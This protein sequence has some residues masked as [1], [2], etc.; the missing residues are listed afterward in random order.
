M[1]KG[2]WGGEQVGVNGELSLQKV[3]RFTHLL[4]FPLV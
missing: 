2:R 1:E 4:A 3:P